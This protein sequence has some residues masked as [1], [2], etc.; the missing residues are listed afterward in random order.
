MNTS[1]YCYLICFILL[2]IAIYLSDK[3]KKAAVLNAVN[4]NKKRERENNPMIQLAKQFIGKEC[5]IY[6]MDS[7]LNSI[8][9]VITSVSENGITV[10]G[11]DGALEAI[12]LDY[13]TRIREYPRNK[14]GKKKSVI[15]D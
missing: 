9:G 2:F 10:E 6:T 4:K 1:Y 12:N 8:S 14:K 3:R 7:G 11:K 15:L 13:V 5:L